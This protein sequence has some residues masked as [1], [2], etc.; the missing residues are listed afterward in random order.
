M[1]L[2]L[3]IKNLR[4]F[5]DPQGAQISL[6]N[7]F[8]ALIGANNSGKS[9]LLRFF[10][11][12]RHLFNILKDP[13]HVINLTTAGH[14]LPFTVPDT[15]LESQDVFS[16][17]NDRPIEIE[18]RF[19]RQTNSSLPPIERVAIIIRRSVPRQLNF[20]AQFY[21]AQ[22]QSV[23]GVTKLP[24]GIAHVGTA[25]TFDF[26]EVLAGFSE[27]SDTFYIG[28]F[29]NAVQL[30]GGKY[31]DLRVGNAAVHVWADF[32]LS[33]QKHER[34]ARLQNELRDIFGF[35]SLKIDVSKEPPMLR[36][37][38]NGKSQLLG[39]VGSGLSQFVIILSQLALSKPAYVLIDE[40]ELHLH[41]SLQSKFLMTLGTY[42][43]RGV[44]FG[45]H[46]I[47]LARAVADR[48]YSVR[49]LSEGVSETRPFE[50]SGSYPELLG[51]LS[52]SGYRDLGFKKVLLV[53][54]PTE[55]KTFQ[56]FLRFVGVDH[57][58]VILQ[59]GGSSMINGKR[60]Q[61]LA[62]VKRICEE[63][64]AVI[65]SERKSE[66]DPL[67]ND[68]AD[69]EKMCKGLGIDCHVLERRAT[70]NYF[71]GHAIEK[72]KGA[73]YKALDPYERLKDAVQPWEKDAN[74]RI[75]R[76][77]TWDDLEQTDLGNFLEKLK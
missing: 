49:R 29:R 25:A 2:G 40:P 55:V 61:E 17:T 58:V 48:I 36:L 35:E 19:P 70:E 31:F 21:V 41:A 60:D 4:C 68:R 76:E 37:L 77:M 71:S 67:P 74:W 52:Y 62:E 75:A 33:K 22:N 3:T 30:E 51:E 27:L 38:I 8:T 23:R 63:S 69:F 59:L 14:S 57:Q 20:T 5:P 46:N 56:Q 43:K 39:E 16:D 6:G 1:K 64:F 53:E 34:A 50:S 12:F 28:S 54:G 32:T 65:D 42:S 18:V 13:A 10:Y 26:T 9:S 45:T 47:G 72:V 66:K 7:D 73:K 11:E 24:D 44:V 15:I